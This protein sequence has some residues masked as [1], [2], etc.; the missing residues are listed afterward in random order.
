MSDTDDRER[1]WSLVK[2]IRYAM[3]TTRRDDGQ[4]HSRPM[5]VQNG[6]FEDDDL[7]FFMSRRNGPVP[8]LERDR[9]VHVGF[10][11]PDG[12]RYVSVSGEAQ[13]V[14]DPV[15]ARAMWS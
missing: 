3:F 9:V 10:A 13:V 15:R 8:D 14:D 2:D 1:L 4:L 7:W 12:D 6:R 5:T 11:D